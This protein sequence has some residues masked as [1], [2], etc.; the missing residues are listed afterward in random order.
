V[1]SNDRT[2]GV[3]LHGRCV[4]DETFVASSP[5]PVSSLDSKNQ[6]RVFSFA[7]DYQGGI[8]SEDVPK[9][10][11]ATIV[12]ASPGRLT[13]DEESILI[14][15][16]SRMLLLCSPA[17]KHS[18]RCVGCS[19]F[20]LLMSTMSTLLTP[21]LTLLTLTP[22]TLRSVTYLQYPPPTTIVRPLDRL[23]LL[24]SL[25][26]LQHGSHSSSSTYCIVKSIFGQQGPRLPVGIE[27]GEH[28]GLLACVPCSL[29]N[30]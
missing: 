5:S 22:L 15:F 26:P 25:L 24:P 23:R 29:T 17:I 9:P 11:P 20:C 28:V 13:S 12:A 6:N 16:W 21:P 18:H 19:F 4:T 3:P 7:M 2:V 8:K 14:R 1:N 10:T 27:G 30:A